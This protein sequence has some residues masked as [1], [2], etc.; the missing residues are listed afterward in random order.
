MT[1]IRFTY[2]LSREADQDLEEIFDYTVRK[3]GL[4]QAINYVSEFEETFASL[5]ANPEL[6]RK[7]DEIRSDLR[8]FVKGNHTIFYRILKNHIRILRVLHGSRDIIK[9]FQ[10]E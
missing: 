10:L 6:G 8:S 7:R 3:F 9:F 2:R 1:Q 4:E 5:M